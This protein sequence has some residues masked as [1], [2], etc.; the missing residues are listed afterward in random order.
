MWEGEGRRVE[1]SKSKMDNAKRFVR[2]TH[3]EKSG[4]C[5]T[6]FTPARAKNLTFR[7]LDFW[8][9]RLFLFSHECTEI[10]EVP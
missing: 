2:R 5:F 7:L 6:D 4:Y 8:T 1:K 9:L 10:E 3:L